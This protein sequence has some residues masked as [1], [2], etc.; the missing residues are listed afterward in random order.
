[1]LAVGGAESAR[2]GGNI[3]FGVVS[4]VTVEI[5]LPEGEDTLNVAWGGRRSVS[6]ICRLA[7]RG[8]AETA[9]I[10]RGESIAGLV[11]LGL[12]HDVR[13]GRELGV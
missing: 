10:G 3:V 5:E 2:S 1:M 9:G 8:G 6:V 11:D 4:P 12:T 13:R 7:G